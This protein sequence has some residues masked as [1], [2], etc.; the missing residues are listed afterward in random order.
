MRCSHGLFLIF[1][2]CM[3]IN[4]LKEWDIL[5]FFTKWIYISPSYLH[6]HLLWFTEGSTVHFCEFHSHQMPAR[7]WDSRLLTNGKKCSLQLI[8]CHVLFSLKHI[9]PHQ[10]QTLN[11]IIPRCIITHIPRAKFNTTYIA[12]KHIWRLL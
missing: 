12:Y 4:Y 1:F 7:R 5:V 10:F 6:T 8:V 3:T 2:H 9:H 11:S